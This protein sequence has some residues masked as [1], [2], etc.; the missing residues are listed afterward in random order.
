MVGPRILVLDGPKH[1]FD[2]E[3]SAA[4]RGGSYDWYYAVESQ[5]LD[6]PESGWTTGASFA[7]CRLLPNPLPGSR[8][9][10][11]PGSVTPGSCLRSHWI[12]P[13]TEIR[14]TK[15]PN[16]IFFN[17]FLVDDSFPLIL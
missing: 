9:E 12:R 2:T 3:A 13:R 8:P 17:G 5:N 16:K 14:V 10:G 4:H 11:V 6:V 1:V 15:N 7:F